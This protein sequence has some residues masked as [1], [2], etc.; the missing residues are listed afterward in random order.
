MLKDFT[1]TDLTEHAARAALAAGKVSPEIINSVIVGS[2]T[3]VGSMENLLVGRD[4]SCLLQYGPIDSYLC[5][6]PRINQRIG[7]EVTFIV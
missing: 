7:N 4:F 3:Q 6:E 5:F 2:V 1:A